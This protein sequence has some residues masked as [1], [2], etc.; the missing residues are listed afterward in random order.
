MSS[1]ARWIG[2][3]SVE[4]P[5]STTLTRYSRLKAPMTVASTQMSVMVPVTISEVT[6][7]A[8]RAPSSGVPAKPSYQR[9]RTTSS[10]GAGRS[11][12]TVSALGVEAADQ[13]RRRLGVG[14][15]G[16]GDGQAL[17][18]EKLEQRTDHGHGLARRRHL[19]RL[20]RVEEAALHVHDEQRRASRLERQLAL[21][22]LAPV[23]HQAVPPSAGRIS[24]AISSTCAGS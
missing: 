14:E 8:R 3:Q 20:A 17:A 1:A 6:P 2:G 4:T 22:R 15:L 13:E 23:G 10:P 5:S 18:P 19:H 9:L 24:R 11:A 21:E 7:R 16:E 12:S